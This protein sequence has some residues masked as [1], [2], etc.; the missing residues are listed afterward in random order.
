MKLKKLKINSHYHLKDLEFDFTYPKG[1]PKAG[2]PLDKICFIGQSATGKTNLLHILS[3]SIL[4]LLRVEIVN[5]QSLWIENRNYSKT[6]ENGVLELIFEGKSLILSEKFLSFNNQKYYY[7]D[8][9]SGGSITNLVYNLKNQ[10][11]LIYFDSNYVSNEN[12]KYFKTNPLEIVFEKKI[13]TI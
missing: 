6:L 11:K 12:L 8:S 5:N 9:I 7:D 13:L 10:N 2:Q 3:E 1:H 4:Y